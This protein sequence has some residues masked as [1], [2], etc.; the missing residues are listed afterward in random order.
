MA[1]AHVYTQLGNIAEAWKVSGK[2]Y[3]RMFHEYD[4]VFIDVLSSAALSC[5]LN[6][7]PLKTSQCNFFSEISFPC[8]IGLEITALPFT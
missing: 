8:R 7:F 2:K 3:R 6:F 5:N 4:P 1:T